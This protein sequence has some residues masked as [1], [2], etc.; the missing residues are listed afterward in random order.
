[1]TA[2]KVVGWSLLALAVIFTLGFIFTGE[3]LVTY[4][5]FAPKYANV[6]REVFTNTQSFVQGK[7]E[8]L[9]KLKYQ[10]LMADGPQK[11]ALRSLIM[12]EARSV[13]M[14]KMPPDIQGFVRTLEGGY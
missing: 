4:M 10:Y 5:F 14:Q 12:D 3:D 13:D 1:M 6:Q 11:Q 7:A 9:G 2:V 8:Y